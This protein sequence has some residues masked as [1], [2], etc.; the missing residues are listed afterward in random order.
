M[1]GIS[2]QIGVLFPGITAYRWLG[3]GET[4]LGPVRADVLPRLVRCR[5]GRGFVVSTAALPVRR[6]L[7]R[8]VEGDGVGFPSAC[9]E[10]DNRRRPLSGG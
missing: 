5:V 4:R 6:S 1:E 2:L 9:G 10:G 7:S 3:H 8:G